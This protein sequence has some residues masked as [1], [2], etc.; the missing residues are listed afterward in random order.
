MLRYPYLKNRSNGSLPKKNKYINK[1]EDLFIESENLSFHFF[2][3]AKSNIKDVVW[4][5]ILIDKEDSSNIGENVLKFVGKDKIKKQTQLLDRYGL[6]LQ[7]IVFD[8]THRWD[9]GEGEIFII[10]FKRRLCKLKNIVAKYNLAEFEKLL[11]EIQGG[12]MKMNKPLL[13]STSTLEGYLADM[14]QAKLNPINRTIF[15]GDADL[16]IY[17]NNVAKYLIEFKKH[18]I[19]GEIKHQSFLKYINYDRKKYLALASLTRKLG[20]PFFI[21]LIYSTNYDDNKIKIE[22]IDTN[23]RL[24]ED[25]IIV[26]KGLE[27]AR[28]QI[29]DYIKGK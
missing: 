18:T 29:L 25:K 8:D 28:K 17:D 13:Y 6:S 26:F 5:I 12:S 24:V 7:Y 22:L 14:C 15:P 23:M 21:N 4:S 11:L 19:Y 9:L 10:S 3:D 20:L 1:I 16:V 2:T 27:D